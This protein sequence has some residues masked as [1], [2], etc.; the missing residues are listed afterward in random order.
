MVLG[1]PFGCPQSTI[2]ERLASSMPFLCLDGIDGAGKSTQLLR[3]AEWLRAK[4]IDLVT[5]RDPG[6]TPIGDALRKILL[7]SK[8]QIAPRTEMLLYMTARA[9]LV[10][11]VIRPALSQGKTVLCDRFLLANVVYQGHAGG[12]DPELIWQVGEAAVDGLHPDKYFVLDLPA[13]IAYTRM[14]RGL[15]RMEQRGVAFMEQVREGFLK[16]AARQPGRIE[17]VDANRT[18]DQIFEDLTSR[19]TKWLHK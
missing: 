8:E 5:C 2:H 18:E 3:L 11:E 12:L 1:S 19:L 9:Q 4:P 14:K 13:E 15:D 6:S 16:E 10:S 17:V 7:E